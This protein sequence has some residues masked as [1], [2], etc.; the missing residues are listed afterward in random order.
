MTE[1][2]RGRTPVLAALAV[3]LLCG[4]GTEIALR[5]PHGQARATARPRGT[6]IDG[7]FFTTTVSSS[8]HLISKRN[9]AGSA[10]YKLSST[11][12]P[13]NGLDV[14]PA[15]TI[16]VTISVTPGRLLAV[17][18]LAG[19]PADTAW[20]AQDA[21]ELMPNMVGTPSAAEYVTSA[22]TPSLSS[23]AGAEAA[24]ESYSYIYHGTGNIQVDLVA[25]RGG[26]LILIE[27]DTEPSLAHQGE[28]A[29]Q[30]I[31]RNWRWT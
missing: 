5:S 4:A 24:I 17:Y 31:A 18:H 3:L 30:A 29:M 22:G 20:A 10:L 19:G 2:L 6:T 27:L 21:L 11:G 9:A 25:R 7:G 15:G 13:A 14:P 16:G 26:N 28:A 1:M 8:W 23:L 12:L